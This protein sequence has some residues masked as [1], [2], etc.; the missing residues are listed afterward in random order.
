[1]FK[2]VAPWGP[3]TNVH[4]FNDIL[5][6]VYRPRDYF[7]GDNN[8]NAK[9]L[10]HPMPSDGQDSTVSTQWD[11]WWKLDNVADE[12]YFIIANQQILQI[13]NAN[14]RGYA[15]HVDGP[16]SQVQIDRLDGGGTVVNLNNAAWAPDTDFHRGRMS[17]ERAGALRNFR[18]YV[19]DMV[20]PVAGPTSDVTYTDFSYWGW[21][22]LTFNRT[23]FG[24][25]SCS[26]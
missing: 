16:N 21:D 10:F 3:D 14:I 6:G 7:R 15:I 26:S 5:G 20:T 23:T 9:Y 4:Y 24:G 22:L 11:F 8:A 18:L 2:N 17:R 1:M 13:A 19:D 25:E 12:L